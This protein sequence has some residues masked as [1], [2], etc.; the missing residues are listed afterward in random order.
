MTLLSKSA[1]LCANDLQIED[2]VWQ[3][4][5]LVSVTNMWMPVQG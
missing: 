4:A 3:L 1:I 2:V 5:G